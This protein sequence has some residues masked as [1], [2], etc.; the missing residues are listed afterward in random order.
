[1]PD[2][3]IALISVVVGAAVA[4]IGSELIEWYK[5]PRLEINFEEK[6]GQ[7]PYIP[8]YN[9][10]TKQL[11]GIVHK[12]KYLR[13]VARNKG[14]KPAIN[15]E[16][17]LE[18]AAKNESKEL[19]KV[20]LHWSRNDPLLYSQNNTE[21][22]F[23]PISLNI[24]DEEIVDV[25]RLSYSFSCMPDADHTPNSSPF[26]ESTS[27]RQLQLHPKATYKCKVTIYSS[28]A[29]PK[30]FKFKV[31]WDGTLE[32]FNRAFTKD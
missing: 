16:A 19:N 26:I 1:M 8:D 31:S 22:I 27:L 20:A 11:A 14:K 23:A 4:L 9:D 2:W 5:R 17:K 7:K 24:N 6:Q 10:N 30:A 29:N 25:L 13:L 12:I 3:A 18:L 32:G 28:N 21:K 15:C